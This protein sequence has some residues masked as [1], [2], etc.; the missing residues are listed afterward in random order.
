MRNAV[1]AMQRKTSVSLV[2]SIQTKV[3]TLSSVQLVSANCVLTRN[4]FISLT[5]KAAC[6][7]FDLVSSLLLIKIWTPHLN[8]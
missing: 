1:V 6:I 8:C 7:I 3:H 4:R 2:R 5:L